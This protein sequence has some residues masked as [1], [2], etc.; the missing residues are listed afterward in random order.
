MAVIATTALVRLTPTPI[1][2]RTMAARALPLPPAVVPSE[3]DAVAVRS[4]A[5]R[6]VVDT[7]AAVVAVRLLADVRLAEEDNKVKTK[8]IIEL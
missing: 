7:V 6:S 8:R 5:V 2:V 1:V 4:V 3:A